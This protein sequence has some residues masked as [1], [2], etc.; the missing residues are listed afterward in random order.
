MLLR[1]VIHKML[2]RS[3]RNANIRVEGRMVTWLKVL[4]QSIYLLAFYIAVLSIK[5]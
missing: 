2:R 1:R 3:L 5:E 4:S